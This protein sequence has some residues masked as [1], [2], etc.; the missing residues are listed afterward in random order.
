MLTL[1]AI[2]L[3]VFIFKNQIL[4]LLEPVLELW[5]RVFGVAN[6]YMRIV[7]EDLER[8]SKITTAEKKHN[9][10]TKAQTLKEKGI[11]VDDLDID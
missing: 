7:E 4:S 6:T 11:T 2:A 9:A 5:E 10:K 3:I 8:S 1:I